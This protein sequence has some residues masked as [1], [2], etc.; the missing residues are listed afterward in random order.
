[1]YQ[2]VDTQGISPTA[3]TQGSVSVYQYTKIDVP[4]TNTQWKELQLELELF[5]SIYISSQVAETM[6]SK[7]LLTFMF[8]C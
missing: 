7:L 6:C 4:N 2:F 3:D 8:E 5:D 1:M